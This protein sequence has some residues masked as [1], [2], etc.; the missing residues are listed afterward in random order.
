MIVLLFLGLALAYLIWTLL[1]LEANARKARAM[2]V[3]VVRIPFDVNNNL[4]VI[5]QPLLWK[6]LSHLPVQ[7]RSYP[8]FVRFSHRNWH[9]LEKSSP[10]ER[11]GEVWA[12]VSPGGVHLHV[13]H[14]DAIQEIFSRWRD[15]VRPIK[16]Y[17]ML[18]IY[19]PS[20]LTVGLEDWPRHRK[21][22]AAPFN[23]SMMK[24][25]WDE[26]SR[27][28]Q[29]MLSYW[30]QTKTGIPGM[31][32]DLRTLSLNVLAAT[33]FRESYDFIDSEH[34]SSRELSTASYRDS[35]YIVDKYV[36]LLILIPYRFLTGAIIPRSLARIGHAAVSLKGFMM[37]TITK[38]LAALTA[39]EPGSGGMLTSLVRALDQESAK[40]ANSEDF[41]KEKKRGRLSIDEIL[42]NVFTIN[43]A[44]HDATA[45]TL[46]FVMMLLAAHPEV[47][48]WLHEEIIT[49]H[50]EKSADDVDLSCAMFEQLKRCQAVF[51]ETLRLYSPV[52]GLPKMTSK[53]VQTLR[54]EDKELAI[55]P[56]T[57]IFPLLLG[58][59]TDPRYWNDPNVWKPSRWIIPSETSHEEELLVPQKGT[60]FPW[61]EGPQNCTGKLFSQVEAVAVLARLFRDHRIFVK[62]ESGEEE[63]HA[64]KRARDC[65]DDVNYNLLL[66]MNHPERV[67]LECRQI[68]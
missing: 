62:P 45:N 48:E 8:D 11:F 68:N 57:E 20:V 55:P 30:I 46:A 12:L 51:L 9:F 65:V 58:M 23:Q 36:I 61:S 67:R 19:G 39:G 18:A 15:F 31:P 17:Q 54:I 56:G 40:Q 64:R 35:L 1:C 66:K 53:T 37:K 41:V 34:L 25:V 4:W 22:V 38:E 27:Q 26:T 60:Y 52:T 50:K 43:F 28:T 13:S 3:H 21:A 7:W 29:A 33:A 44:G 59:H 24:F 10:T 16:K 49:V 6:L 14:P 42:G 5:I 2:K 63:S 32:E 47:Q